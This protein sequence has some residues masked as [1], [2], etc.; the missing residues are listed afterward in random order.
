MATQRSRRLR[1]KL[2]IDEFQELG[3]SVAWRFPD[4]TSEE[5]I[6]DTLNQFI[7]E[8]ID[9]NGLAYDGSGYL[10][11]EGLICLQQTGKCTEEHRELVRKWL[12]DRQLLDVKVTELF[13]VWW[14]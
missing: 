12:E 7:N 10:A 1:K 5:V 14:D 11:W 8:A 2:H 3:F 6:D 4:G 13:D 9:P